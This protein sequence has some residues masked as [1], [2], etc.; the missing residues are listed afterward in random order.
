MS[1]ERKRTFDLCL[2]NMANDAYLRA[3]RIASIYDM[4]DE[5][6]RAELLKAMRAE[7]ALAQHLT[8][9][10]LDQAKKAD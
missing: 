7:I 6:E 1:D 2:F 5:Q 4:S 10:I 3:S 8:R 9:R